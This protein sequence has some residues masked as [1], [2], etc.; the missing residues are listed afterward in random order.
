MSKQS[1]VKAKV[2]SDSILINKRLASQKGSPLN[3]ACPQKVK[4]VNLGSCEGIVLY[5]DSN[6]PDIKIHI[7]DFT[8]ATKVVLHWTKNCVQ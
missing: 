3:S 8:P 7:M 5:K 2:V 6:K 4:V 1:V